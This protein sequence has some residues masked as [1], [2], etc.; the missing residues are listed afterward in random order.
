MVT[1]PAKIHFKCALTA[2][3]TS[4]DM[5]GCGRPAWPGVNLG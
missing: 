2:R 3:M 5:L 4:F 1:R